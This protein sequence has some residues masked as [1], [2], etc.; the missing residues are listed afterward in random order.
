MPSHS[1]QIKFKLLK[2]KEQALVCS[3]LPFQFLAQSHLIITK[4]IH[5]HGYEIKYRRWVYDEK[6]PSSLGTS[7]CHPALQKQLLL[8]TS[9][10]IIFT[11]MKIRH[12]AIIYYHVNA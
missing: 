12:H 5:A 9:S 8:L 10:V 1:L 7:H 2:V 11:F 3:S 6:L 4:L